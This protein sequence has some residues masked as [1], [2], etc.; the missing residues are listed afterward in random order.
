MIKRNWYPMKH[1]WDTSF[2]IGQIMPVF[3][4]E[5]TPLDRWN[6]NSVMV[7]RMSPMN[8]P[9]FGMFEFETYY[10]FVPYSQVWTEEEISGYG[11][12][13]DYIG[14]R[15]GVSPTFPTLTHS[16]IKGFTNDSIMT[17]MGVG[18]RGSA[19]GTETLNM[20]GVMA[21]NHCYNHFFQD[22]IVSGKV[23]L[24]SQTLRSASHK[25]NTLL[26]KATDDIEVG[27]VQTVNTSGSQLSVI[28]IQEAF[29]N[30]D[31]AE[32]R[33]RYGDE[34]D[35]ILRMMGVRGADKLN[36]A[37]EL[38]GYAS[39]PVGV[40]EVLN[41]SNTDT[42][43]YVGHGIVTHRFNLRK[44]MF[45][46]WG[47]ILGLAVLRPTSTFKNK[48]EHWFNINN[49][50]DT[51]QHFYNPAF[52]RMSHDVVRGKHIHSLATTATRDSIIGYVPKYE[53]LRHAE[54]VVAGEYLKVDTYDPQIIVREGA[55]NAAAIGLEEAS[56][57][58]RDDYAYLFQSTSEPQMFL[59]AYNQIGKL[60]QIPRAKV[61]YTGAG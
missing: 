1:R 21:Y 51:H 39:S 36:N 52:N 43:E 54:N 27:T 37:P 34:Y 61:S 53:W 28:D 12:F 35:D 42:G 30:Q 50:G 32:I 17:S 19:Q 55:E 5:V 13:K 24:S 9:V 10:F 18:C 22:D 23:A 57:I 60:S 46:E 40:S 6:G 4:Q 47:T 56:I 44:K 59:T 41:T 2:Q 14:Q 8:K 15:E 45:T 3:R 16:Q 7:G 49:E 38:I 25:K 11:E 48:I 26:R 31:W 33:E 20:L 29:E 58:D